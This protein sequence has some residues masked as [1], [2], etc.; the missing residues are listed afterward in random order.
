MTKERERLFYRAPLGGGAIRGEYLASYSAPNGIRTRVLALKGPRPS[1]LD[2]RDESDNI[3]HDLR[4][5]ASNPHGTDKK[6]SEGSR[7][8]S[9]LSVRMSYQTGGQGICGQSSGGGG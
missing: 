2:D 7:E 1:P 9:D 5:R 6:R 3:I 8:R 4:A